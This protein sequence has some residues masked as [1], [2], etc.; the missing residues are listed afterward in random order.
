MNLLV[1][2][3]RLQK[4]VRIF[5]YWILIIPKLQLRHLPNILKTIKGIEKVQALNKRQIEILKSLQIP[6]SKLHNLM[7][8]III[9]YTLL[10]KECLKNKHP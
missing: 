2:V 5:E 9:V 1:P 4:K 10:I 3:D 6:K 7:I 8:L